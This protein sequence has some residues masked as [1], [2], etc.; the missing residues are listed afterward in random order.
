MVFVVYF[1]SFMALNKGSVSVNHRNFSCP[2][3]WAFCP[4]LLVNVALIRKKIDM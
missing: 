1:P 2:K 4:S 3:P